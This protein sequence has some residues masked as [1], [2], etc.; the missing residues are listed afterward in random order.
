MDESDKKQDIDQAK[1]KKEAESRESR[2]KKADWFALANMTAGVFAGIAGIATNIIVGRI[3]NIRGIDINIWLLTIQLHWLLMFFT[4]MLF[5]AVTCYLVEKSDARNK[6]VRAIFRVPSWVELQSFGDQRVAKISY[7]SLAAIPLIVSFIKE[8]PLRIHILNII[9][10][11]LNL[12]ISFFISV[13]L[14][15]AV[16]L[17]TIWCPKE[18]KQKQKEK[19]PNAP[20]MIVGQHEN[21]VISV[22]SESGNEFYDAEIDA[23]KLEFR[24]ICWTAYVLAFS[25]ALL[26]LFRAATK[27]AMA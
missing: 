16:I 8:N 21:S 10:I 11:P 22:K 17:L 24:A 23:S 2:A 4:I 1:Q 14:S 18:F 6:I 25:F 26:L 7:F 15:V 20:I 27:V 5:Y 9:E 19:I 3:D 12:K 13:F